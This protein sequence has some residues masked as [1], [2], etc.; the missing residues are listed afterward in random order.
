MTD[1]EIAI[2]NWP[3]ENRRMDAAIIAGKEK[4]L[5]RKLTEDET[6]KLLIE[7]RKS[8]PDFPHENYSFE[9]KLLVALERLHSVGEDIRNAIHRLADQNEHE[10]GVERAIYHLADMVEKRK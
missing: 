8:H 7:W 4:A 5:G 6:T 1:E 10:G 2:I 9:S 3:G